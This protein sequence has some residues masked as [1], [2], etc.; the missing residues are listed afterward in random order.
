GTGKT[1]LV[2][3]LVGRLRRLGLPVAVVTRGYGRR[4]T[5]R[6]T[7]DIL[8]VDEHCRAE[9]VGDE[10]LLI[11]LRTGV[12]VYVSRDRVAAAQAAIADGAGV[13][14]ADDGLQHLRLERAVEIA[15]VDG[16]RG[17]GN[18]A[19]LP[20]G[21]LRESAARLAGVTAVVLTEAGAGA[22]PG[23]WGGALRMSLAGDLLLPVNGIAIERT[24]RSFASQH[25]HGVAGIGNPRRFFATL[26]SAGLVVI[27]HRFPDHHRYTPADLDFGDGRAVI[28]TEKDA[29]KCRRFAPADCWCLPVSAGFPAGDERTLLR[30]ILMDARLL[31]I[32]AC[33]L[34]KG[35]VRLADADAGKVLVCR[36]DRLAFPVRDGI[37]VMLEEEARPLESNDPLLER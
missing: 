20:A 32:L 24:L 33:P 9:E 4:S 27:A 2:I 6:V 23:A 36:A 30:R 10:A 11:R 12:P 5:G 21:P 1:P 29:V 31:D 17:L 37:P 35:P 16:Q 34:C 26:E 25:V 8:R 22:P 28:M 13:I 14:V 7:T 19:L 3:W 18:G 15:L